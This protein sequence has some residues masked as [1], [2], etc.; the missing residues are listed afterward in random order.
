MKLV[1]IPDESFCFGFC[2]FSFFAQHYI[3]YI[4]QRTL[5]VEWIKNLLNEWIHIGLHARFYA[6]APQFYTLSR[7]RFNY[8]LDLI[9][10][11]SKHDCYFCLILK[12]ECKLLLL[13]KRKLIRFQIQT[14]FLFIFIMYWISCW[15]FRC[16]SWI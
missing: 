2:F 9:R 16:V 4:D 3:W 14:E 1:K 8:S 10:S 11:T 12:T 6:N 13:L 7:W 5:F 15:T